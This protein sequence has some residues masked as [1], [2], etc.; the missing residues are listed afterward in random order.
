MLRI[1]VQ[2]VSALLLAEGHA[3]D[4]VKVMQQRQVDAFETI[5]IRFEH[6]RSF[7]VLDLVSMKEWR[8]R[9][10]D[11]GSCCTEVAHVRH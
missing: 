4:V 8:P 11:R 10:C 5:P 2:N 3:T 1:V 7:L 6:Q 9:C